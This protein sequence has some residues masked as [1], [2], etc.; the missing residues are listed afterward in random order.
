MLKNLT[1]FL[2]FLGIVQGRPQAQDPKKTP[3][4]VGEEN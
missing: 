3:V 1:F 4:I 2:V